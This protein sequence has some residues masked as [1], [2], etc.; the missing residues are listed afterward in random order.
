MWQQLKP[1]NAFARSKPE[2]SGLLY[3]YIYYMKDTC[4]KVTLGE[5]LVHVILLCA[6]PF[7]NRK[8]K[9]F[10][11]LSLIQKAAPYKPKARIVVYHRQTQPWNPQHRAEVTQSSDPMGQ[12]SSARECA[13]ACPVGT[14]TK[15]CFFS[16]TRSP[17]KNSKHLSSTLQ[18]QSFQRPAHTRLRQHSRK[19]E[20]EFS[21]VKNKSEKKSKEHL[22]YSFKVS[23]LDG[24][25]RFLLKWL[26]I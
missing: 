25:E 9:D 26:F 3:I 2:D 4:L 23:L 18:L 14:S 12:G 16:F 7:Q 8:W 6:T 13:W 17:Q 10:S 11:L 24:T 21:A 1:A 22:E 15:E 20:T 19:E 5:S